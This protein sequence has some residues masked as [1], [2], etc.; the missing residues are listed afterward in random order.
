MTHEKLQNIKNKKKHD[1]F[2]MDIVQVKCESDQIKHL[3]FINNDD[4]KTYHDTYVKLNAIHN[5]DTISYYITEND[6]IE[7]GTG[8]Q[9]GQTRNLKNRK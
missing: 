1:G 4:L 9:Y 8:Q 5:M 2:S 6:H 7:L 3:N